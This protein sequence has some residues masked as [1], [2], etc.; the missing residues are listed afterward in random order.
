MLEILPSGPEPSES[1]VS[2][3]VVCCYKLPVHLWWSVPYQELPETGHTPQYMLLLCVCTLTMKS[4]SYQPSVTHYTLMKSVLYYRL[5][6]I[7]SM[8]CCVF[9]LP[10][11][12]LVMK[13]H[14][15]ICVAQYLRGNSNT[16]CCVLSMCLHTLDVKPVSSYSPHYDHF[17]CLSLLRLCTVMMKYLSYQ[18]HWL[19]TML[20]VI[21]A[22]VH[23]PDASV[24]FV[25]RPWRW[26]DVTW[27]PLFDF[28]RSSMN[29]GS[30]WFD[31]RVVQL[32]L[33]LESWGDDW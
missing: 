2:H 13:C 24:C 10:V 29:L 5:P 22:S 28:E 27:V 25:A 7:S 30:D 20:C 6:A 1:L 19:H 26:P 16:E 32:Y 9:L 17:L 14:T 23:T 21:T 12:T 11:C 31:M 18:E 4:V 8:A 3:Y 15:S 33:W